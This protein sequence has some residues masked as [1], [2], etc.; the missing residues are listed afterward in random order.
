M[1]TFAV[2]VEMLV[3][4]A[5]LNITRVS[6]DMRVLSADA[7]ARG[8]PITRGRSDDQGRIPPTTANIDY[9]DNNNALDGENPASPYYRKIGPATPVRVTIEGSVRCE[10]E[11]ATMRTTTT[12]RT[13]ASPI[14]QHEIEL[15]GQTMRLE[16]ARKPIRSAAT[17][18]FSRETPWQWWAL[19]SGPGLQVLEVPSSIAVQK[20][21]EPHRRTDLKALR[22]S[23]ATAGGSENA[24]ASGVVSGGSTAG[25]PGSAGGVDV[26]D[27]GQLQAVF[28]LPIP[29][30][31]LTQLIVEGAFQFSTPVDAA[32]SGSVVR[33]NLT[34]DVTIQ[35]FAQP[36]DITAAMVFEI[37]STTEIISQTNSQVIIDDG[38]W[39]HVIMIFDRVSSTRFDYAVY[40]DGTP[41][42]LGTTA[43]SPL[44]DITQ[45]TLSAT[46]EVGA[47][48][49]WAIWKDGYLPGGETQGWT[50][51]SGFTG[52]TPDS[53]IESLLEEAG[54][55]T[56]QVGFD[57]FSE[58][59]EIE[60]LPAGALM[61][62]V[63]AAAQAGQHLVYE[64]RDDYTEIVRRARTN[65]YN[66]VPK[67]TLRYAQLLTGLTAESNAYDQRI[68]NDVTVSNGTDEGQFVVP[69]DDPWHWTT[70]APPLG[71]GVRDVSESAP[72]A[73]EDL[74]PIAA[75]LAHL[76]SWRERR[77]LA[78]TLELGKDSTAFP[79]TGFTSAERTAIRALE[80]GDV[81]AIDTSSAPATIPYDEVRL[82][83]Q[84]YSETVAL[85]LHTITLNVTPADAWEVEVTDSGP[86]S[87][88]A[89]KIDSDDTSVKLAPGDGP[90]WSEAEDFFHISVNGDPMTVE[91]IS[92]NT[93]AY[94][95]TG[96]A[97]YADNAAVSPALPAGITPDVGQLLLCWA[98][99]R[100]TTAT[101][102]TP[103][104]WTGIT[105]QGA[106]YLFA[107]YYV[108][109]DVAPTCTPSGGAAGTTIG[110]Q[111]AAFTG[112][113]MML[114]KNLTNA[115]SNSGVSGQEN[116][117]AQ[118]VAYTALT[119]RRASDALFI[120][121]KKDDDWT[122]V[123][124]P[125]SMTEVGDSSSLLGNDMGMAWYF[126][127][128]AG[129]KQSTATGSLVVTGGAAAVSAAMSVIL[130]PLQ[131]A[132]VTRAIAAAGA[133]HSPGETIH[134]W[135][136][137]VNAL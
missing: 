79:L 135:R 114:D 132:T 86:T 4:G 128:S 54:I 75:W 48:T 8:I 113:S 17:R 70:Q 58:T 78:I 120:F 136:P 85:P 10:I 31:G 101:I 9:L 23:P 22:A 39:H 129:V 83:L 72:V 98:G 105:A 121:G 14:I 50:T 108:T 12:T 97:S 133:A 59:I 124:P 127:A 119:G 33:L 123:A 7:G 11:L 74:R 38:D 109:G 29:A 24:R 40:I 46:G 61:D 21:E 126:L 43:S 112:L 1:A 28:A 19:E 27:G 55:A 110:A 116:G 81:I 5:W 91:S 57:L 30:V 42:F 49:Q 87:A 117:S 37:N 66:Q 63:T 92:T 36:V 122:G 41:Y 26:S 95:A 15:A 64:K 34:S 99:R 84:G 3:D 62:Q 118:N 67:I 77:Y 131:T 45:F 107:K 51:I 125:A 16:G 88:I 115:L 56:S 104:G 96:A 134:A 52:L 80:L 69:D 76:R 94:V 89:N 111:V 103:S 32:G 6:A 93:P 13:G 18:R 20:P 68:A 137:G 47:V 82:M 90:A 53:V 25:P 44:R 73:A 71:A 106:G 35:L 100:G 65:L 102:A 130:R 60:A 2:V